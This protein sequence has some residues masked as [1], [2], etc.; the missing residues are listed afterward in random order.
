MENTEG[1]AAVDPVD[2]LRLALL[3]QRIDR[4]HA[5]L[6][7]RT[8]G[9]MEAL[10]LLMLL[11]GLVLLISSGARGYSRPQK[12]V[13]GIV[14]IVQGLGLWWYA[15]RMAAQE[16]QRL[17]QQLQAMAGAEDAAVIASAADAA[18]TFLIDRRS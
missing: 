10:Q 8:F 11:I 6:R 4:L 1:A 12:L 15:R 3:Q 13:L 18:R 9:L 17:Q 2:G 16:L 14:L 5:R 7:F